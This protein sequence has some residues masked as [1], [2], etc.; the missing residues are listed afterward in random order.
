ILILPLIFVAIVFI[1][2]RN[3]LAEDLRQVLYTA[4]AFALLGAFLG[5]LPRLF[6]T[7]TLETGFQVTVI[8]A[9]GWTWFSTFAFSLL[10]TIAIGLLHGSIITIFRV[11]SFIVT[12]AGLLGWNGVVLKI[13]GNGGTVIIQD[14]TIVG[15]ANSYLPKIWEGAEQIIIPINW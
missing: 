2:Q 11:P 15:I 12:L 9:Q 13:I 10:V 4:L 6:H 7:E 5:F 1:V 8:Y 14:Q 3:K